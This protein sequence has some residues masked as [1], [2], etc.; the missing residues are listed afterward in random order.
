MLRTLFALAALLAVTQSLQLPNQGAVATRRG[1]IAAAGA[2]LAV[3]VLPA[4]AAIQ[5]PINML[6]LKNPSAAAKDVL[7]TQVELNA[8][9]KSEEAFVMGQVDG[10]EKAPQLPKAIPFT[11]FQVSLMWPN[12]NPNPHP[13]PNPTPSLNPNPGPNPNPNPNTNPDPNLNP[14]LDPNPHQSLEKDA[15][16]EFMEIAIDYAE[17]MRNAR[18]L[19]K[20][21]KLTKQKVTV[22]SKEPGKPRMTMEI[23]YGAAEGSNLGSTKEYSSRAFQEAVGASIAL[24]AAVEALPKKK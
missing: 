16:P 3:R 4:G 2:A 23:E 10:D 5:D 9:V 24:N 15:G 21:A 11:T 22:S 13:S 17:A 1:A 8:F 20:L 6:S 14:D 19:T 18:D 12:L 7:T